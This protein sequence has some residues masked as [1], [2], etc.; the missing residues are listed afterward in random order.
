MKLLRELL[1]N[2]PLKLPDK[3]QCTCWKK[4]RWKYWRSFRKS[5]ESYSRGLPEQFWVEPL[6]HVITCVS[7]VVLGLTPG[8]ISRFRFNSQNNFH[9]NC[10]DSRQNFSKYSGKVLKQISAEILEGF[11]TKVLDE[12]PVN[13]FYSASGG[14]YTATPETC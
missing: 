1:E 6:E 13:F 10:W 2:A 8:S 9:R 11:P 14:T 7:L 4:S 5:F 12:L 3:F